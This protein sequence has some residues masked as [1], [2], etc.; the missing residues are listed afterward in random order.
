MAGREIS[1]IRPVRICRAATP[2]SRR[3]RM[4]QRSV[5]AG[6]ITALGI[7]LAAAGC[8]APPPSEP[9]AGEP[10]AIA[11]GAGGGAASTDVAHLNEAEPVYSHHC[12]V[13][14]LDEGELQDIE[15]FL[16]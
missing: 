1:A 16:A 6:M 11:Q 15:N 7:G 8:G 2:N 10:G 9:V 4:L 13:R 5:I 14:D 12:A 3:T